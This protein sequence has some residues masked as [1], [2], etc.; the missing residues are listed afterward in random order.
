MELLPLPASE[1][2]PTPAPLPDPAPTLPDLIA[3]GLTCDVPSTTLLDATRVS[4]D[5]QAWKSRFVAYCDSDQSA[6]VRK[7]SVWAVS[8]GI[9]FGMLLAVT[10]ADRDLFDRLAKFYDDHLD[11]FGLMNWS[12]E[13]CEPPGNNGSHSATDADLDAAMALLMA[14]ARWGGY[15]ERATNLINTIRQHATCER[16]QLLVLRPGD[17]WGSCDESQ[18]ETN[19]SYFSPAY[20]RAFAAFLPDQADFWNRMVT[21]TY[22]LLQI[23]QGT[24]DGLVSDWCTHAGQVSRESGYGYEAC[25]VPWRI[26]MDYAWNGSPQAQGILDQLH[27]ARLGVRSDSNSCFLGGDALTSIIYSQAAFDAAVR[28]WLD[29]WLDDTLYY[30]ATLRNL[31]MLLAA[32]AIMPPGC[33]GSR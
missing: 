24:M 1:S 4:Y 22:I 2:E 23:N 30:P 6:Y 19:P 29:A 13:G 10:H 17:A 9:G 27:Q 5:Y 8:E 33:H 32:G 25:R 26:A 18:P 21:D 11:E 14:H 15:L 31:Y 28:A 20:Y 7:D 12:V 16:F 3:A